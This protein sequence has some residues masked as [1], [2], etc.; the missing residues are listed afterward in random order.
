MTW[1]W[2]D[3]IK[4]G[5][6]AV[7][8]FLAGRVSK[9]LDRRLDRKDAE[10]KRAP[11]FE[12]EHVSGQRFRLVNTGD[13]DA[14][15]VTLDLAGH[16]EGLTRDVPRGIDLPAG[17]GHSMILGATGSTR[18]PDQYSVSCDQLP[19]PVPVIPRRTSGG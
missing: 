1:D 7:I 11:A 15:G 12:L 18:R 16:A 17:A 3:L 6:T 19:N 2:F 5:V 9:R 13:A 8:A 14:T 10:A 4:I